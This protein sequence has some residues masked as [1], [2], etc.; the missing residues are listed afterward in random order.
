VEIWVLL[1]IA[2]KSKLYEA[3]QRTDKKIMHIALN[4]NMQ[5]SR[6]SAIVSDLINKKNMLVNLK[7]LYDRIEEKI[8]ESKLKVI[9]DFLYAREDVDEYCLKNT[10]DPIAFT[11]MVLSYANE[12]ADVL[13]GLKLTVGKMEEDY[14]SLPLVY[15]TLLMIKRMLASSGVKTPG[16]E[17]AFRHCSS[18]IQLAF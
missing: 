3:V 7:V 9:K 1:I 4:P 18:F 11:N 10:C 13:R 12:G 6:Q 17:L 16:M 5:A 8:D 15:M 2:I 14:M